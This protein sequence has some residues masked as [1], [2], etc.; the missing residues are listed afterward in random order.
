MD[1]VK[2]NPRMAR[3]CETKVQKQN[4][5]PIFGYQKLPLVSLIEAVRPL[6]KPTNGWN[7]YI[8]EA[9]T[10]CHFPSEHNLTREESAA[11]YLYTMQT[12][13][14][15]ELNK[16]LRQKNRKEIEPWFPFLKLFNS[17]LDKLPDYRG[18]LWRGVN[19][20]LSKEFKGDKVYTWWP[21]TSCSEVPEVVKS[22]M[23]AMESTLFTID[24]KNGKVISLY[25]YFPNEKEVL[26][27]MGT[28]FNAVDDPTTFSELNL[29]HLID[30]NSKILY[31]IA[32]FF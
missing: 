16:T 1:H 14:Y 8:G 20:N 5:T 10:D 32:L 24:S 22:F 2:Q 30:I 3:Y 18:V 12:S 6:I 15:G 4:L 21:F 11:I 13:F 28:T 23:D 29:I 7:K 17:A 26:L 9:Y 31:Q 27:R 19:I 25:S